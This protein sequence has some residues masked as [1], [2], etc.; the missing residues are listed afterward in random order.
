P[1]K[2]VT[3]KPAET[4]MG[5]GKGAPEYWVSVIKPG[6]VMFELAGV[7][8]ELAREAM[9][10]AAHKLPIKTKFV[11]RTEAGGEEAHEG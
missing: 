4:R 1:D 3:K 6:R 9:R 8:E 7:N 5:S 11:K 2:P 10:L